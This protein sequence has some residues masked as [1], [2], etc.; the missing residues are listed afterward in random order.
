[1]KYVC[2]VILMVALIGCIGNTQTI[3][4][5][6]GEKEVVQAFS[7]GTHYIKLVG[8]TPTN[9]T[10]VIMGEGEEESLGYHFT[11]EEDQTQGVENTYSERMDVK[12]VEIMED[13]VLVEIKW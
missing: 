8:K 12:L 6:V 10:F 2:I 5:Q 11:I 4:L 7:T 1:M 9:A 3:S 13:S